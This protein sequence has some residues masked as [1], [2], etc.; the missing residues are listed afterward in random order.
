MKLLTIEITARSPLAFPERKAG[1]QFRRSLDYVPGATIYGALGAQLGPRYEGTEE[2]FRALFR[3]IRCHN[4]YP[5]W[6]GDEW[7]RPLPATAEKPKGKTDDVLT[8][9][10][11]ER[12]CCEKLQPP[13]YLFSLTDSEGR[14]QEGAR[15]YHAPARADDLRQQIQRSVTQRVL[16]R[17]AI[18][19]RRGTAQEGLLYSPLVLSEVTTMR[20]YQWNEQTQREQ[21]VKTDFPTR[22]LGSVA[23]PDGCDLSIFTD[24]LHAITFLGGRTTSGLGQVE[25]RVRDAAEAGS[26]AED[27]QTVRERVEALTAAFRQRAPLYEHFGGGGWSANGSIFTINL[28]SHAILYEHG[29]QP[30]MVLTGAM[31]EEATGVRAKL[32]RS[33]ATSGHAGGWHIQWGAP[34]PSEVSTLMGSVF[35]FQTEQ[36]Q[37]LETTEYE[38]LA[39]LQQ[40]GI[41]ERRAEG[42][43]QVRICDEFHI[44]SAFGKG[45]A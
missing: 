22:F 23:L 21:A 24:A 3:A 36:G 38:R 2:E 19:R 10:L 11:I 4:A 32:L 14:A 31:L 16:T 6:L 8:D 5:A 12:V 45:G 41:G 40:A 27:A 44:N 35:V 33:F 39:R 43:G 9:T 1:T 17:V 28:L 26:S 13:A 42:F 25:I 37:E 20:T 18:N 15:G 30:T 34:K 7:S 29:W